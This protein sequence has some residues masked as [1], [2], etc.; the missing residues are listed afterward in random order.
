MLADVVLPAGAFAEKTGT[1]T[2]T[3]RHVQMGRQ[4]LSPPGDARQDLWIIQ[5]MARRLGLDW[6]EAGPEAVFAE[7]AALMPSLAGITWDRLETEGGLTTPAGKAIL[8]DDHF[9]TNDGRALL[10]PASGIAPAELADA[11]Y[12]FVLTTGR[13]LEHWHTGSMTRRSAVLDALR[14][15]AEITVN[16]DDLRDL[17]LT[18]EGM[19][20]MESRRGALKAMARA[21]AR[22][23]RGLVFMAFCYGEAAAN[24]LT[25]PVLDPVAKIPELKVSAVRLHAL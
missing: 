4:V 7:M 6:D 24:M 13:V 1:F 23:P 2:N 25:N 18:G 10:V 22:L 12:P 11:E 8:F 16:P 20:R 21:D 15:D 14:P 19:L 17:G 5:E 9:P 3:D